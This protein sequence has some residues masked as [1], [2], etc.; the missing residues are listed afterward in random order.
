MQCIVVADS[1]GAW[2]YIAAYKK[3]YS[4]LFMESYINWLYPL[5][6]DQL[7]VKGQ[8]PYKGQKACSQCVLFRSS[9]VH[10]SGKNSAVLHIL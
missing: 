5:V 4:W 10:V 1:G 6:M 7:S 2:A 9:T 3:T 8:P